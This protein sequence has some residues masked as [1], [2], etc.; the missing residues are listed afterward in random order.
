MCF[1]KKSNNTIIDDKPFSARNWILFSTGRYADCKLVA[2][3]MT[4]R[5][6]GR[7]H[8]LVMD[9]CLH[10]RPIIP[11]VVPLDGGEGGNVHSRTL[12]PVLEVVAANG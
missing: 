11:P 3:V 12:G 9:F 7:Q 1:N 4:R 5:R 10:N 6:S 8:Q 2:V